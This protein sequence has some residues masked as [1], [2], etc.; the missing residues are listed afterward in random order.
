MFEAYIRKIVGPVIE[1]AA[2]NAASIIIKD[3]LDR[4]NEE[5]GRRFS[6]IE[7][8]KGMAVA[9]GL[10]QLFQKRYFDICLFD[11]LVNVAKIHP[12]GDIVRPLRI[13]H[14]MDWGDIP[15]DY[16]AEVQNKIMAMFVEG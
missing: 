5:E 10:K 1:K 7:K 14:C 4:K 3:D 2:F 9:L 8:F 6:D 16:R 13:L 12:D 15:K 11:Q